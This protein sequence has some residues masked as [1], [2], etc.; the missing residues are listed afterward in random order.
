MTIL[1]FVWDKFTCSIHIGFLTQVDH[2][3]VFQNY[4]V[5]PKFSR[6]IEF[7]STTQPEKKTEIFYHFEFYV[8]DKT[9]ISKNGFMYIH[10]I[11]V[12]KDL[13]WTILMYGDFETFK[14]VPFKLW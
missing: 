9:W 8:K 2:Q 4:V 7:V 3:T 5:V 11:R 12:K 6:Y 14:G 10:D 1:E 13:M